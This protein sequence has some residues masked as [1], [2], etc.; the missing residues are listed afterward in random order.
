MGALAQVHAENGDMVDDGQQAMIDAG[1]TGPEGHPMSRPEATEAEATHRAIAIADQVNVPLYV[2][3]VMSKSAAK[4]ITEAKEKGINVYGEP[5]AVAMAVDGREMYDPDW[6]HAAGHV[7]SP[8]LREDPTTKDELAKLLRS[9]DLDLVGTDNATFS[10]NQKAL[11]KDDFRLIPNG[12]NG[13]ED[14]MSIVWHKCV[15]GLDMSPSDFVR[16]TSTKAAM[17][18]NM[19]PRK[20]HVAV[21]SDAD[22]VVWDGDAQRT[23]TDI[24]KQYSTF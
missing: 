10:A 5:L 9:G 11:G 23:V 2:V 16:V 12:C 21:G 20:G 17:L 8:P 22:L 3:H 7:M 14:R 24:L 6:R 15:K 1:I 13:I 18:F 4:K 19:Y